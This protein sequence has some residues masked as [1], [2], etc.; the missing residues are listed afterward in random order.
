MKEWI[1]TEVENCDCKITLRKNQPSLSRQ[2]GKI[3]SRITQKCEIKIRKKL[4]GKK[5]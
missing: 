1:K 4:Q 2:L 5:V 3:Q